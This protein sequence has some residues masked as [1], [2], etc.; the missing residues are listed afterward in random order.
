MRGRGAIVA[1]GLFAAACSGGDGG[2]ATTTEGG[3]SSTS[4]DEPVAG[5][6][7]RLGVARLLSLDP[8]DVSPESPS[9]SIAADLLYDGLTEM[10]DGGTAAPGLAE[11]WETPDGGVTWRFFLRPDAVFADG[12]RVVAA[13]VEASLERV[14][15]RGA[16][17]LAAA[18]LDA[19]VDVRALDATTVEVVFDRPVA[20]TPEL[21]TAPA[22]GVVP[23]GV[24]TIDPTAAASGPFR[25]VGVAGDMLHLV[26]AR[27]GGAYVDGVELHQF[28][29]LGAAYDSFEAGAL[30]WTLVPPTR[31]E[32][33]AEAHGAE[34]FV[35]FQAEL[36]FG[37][38]LADPTFADVRFRRAIVTA[39]DREAVV[40]AVYFGFAEGLDTIVPVGV[41]GHDASRCGAG[42]RHDPDAARALLA[43]AFPNGGVPE[44]VIDHEDG[45]DE[46][47]LA[48]TVEQQLETVGIP[49][50][51]RPHAAADFGAFAV[52]GQQALVRLG[53]IGVA[54]V[55][56]VYLDPL[57][58]TGGSDNVTG[59][60]DPAVDLLLDA[61]ARALDP[62]ERLRLLGE[63]ESLVLAAAA[64]VPI[65]QFRLLSVSSP[66]VQD[67]EVGVGGTFDATAVWLSR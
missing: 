30:D 16:A 58:R 6:T 48:Q 3:G 29:D 22:F 21:L 15:A 65:A 67:L 2:A 64:I 17:S 63:A 44:V 4:A 62:P 34:G 45:P 14:A 1:L 10:G 11:R 54:A 28:D 24:T 50:V 23:G 51:L 18:R 25:L 33:A 32:A 13:D 12:R 38:N 43:E 36:F 31:A 40:R 20:S 8:A 53:W 27:D 26:R 52:S 5:G 57:F 9:A 49:A 7:L 39:V 66:A 41:P 46:T 42:C 60:S 35:P 47:A 37:F 61:A 55:P 56:D 19:L 59:F